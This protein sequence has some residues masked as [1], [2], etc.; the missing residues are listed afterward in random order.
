MKNIKFF[1]SLALAAFG[2][3]TFNSCTDLEVKEQDSLVIASSGAGSGFDAAALLATSYN[4]LSAYTDQANIY[5]LTEH[6]SDEMI[7]PTRGVDWG[8]NGVWRTLHAHSWDPTHSFVTNAWNQL[9]SRV[10]TCNQALSGTPTPEQKAQLQ[11]LRAYN[12][13]HIMDFY[14]KVPF[15]EFNEGVDVN[16]RVL[17]RSEAFDFVE[18]DLL[19]A[20]PNLLG[21]GPTADNSVATKAACNALLARLYLNKAV[22]KSASPAGPYT[23]DNGDM[24]KVIAACEA[25]TDAGFTLEPNYFDNFKAG[26]TNEVLWVSSQGTPQNR[27]FMTMHYNQNP[28]G[29][30]GFATLADFYS[31]FEDGDQRKGKEGKKDGTAFQGTGYGF[32]VGQ[33]YKDDGSELIDERTSKPLKFTPDV[34][35]SGAATD[36]GIRVIKYHNGEYGKYIL[37]RL[38][39]VM[40]MKA[41]AQMRKGDNAGALATVNTLRAAR[42]AAPLTSLDAAAMADER[43]REMY[44]E[45]VRRTDQIRFGTFN[46]TWA[47][48]TNTETFRVLYP[49]PQQAIDSNPNLRQNDGY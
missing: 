22:Y 8:D 32:L 47:E 42:S 37:L 41:E 1:S 35:L 29:W 4:D 12:M 9:N 23:F 17:T 36:K 13:F 49:I 46:G 48:K 10:F 39:D 21:Q 40:T 14:G 43:A 45:G 19:E 20:L 28:S 2:L 16:P 5:A 6:P 25:V 24:D 18:K 30:N 27:V 15:R 3:M 26:A 33:Q 34:P 31:K 38:G 44:W 11:F 7:P